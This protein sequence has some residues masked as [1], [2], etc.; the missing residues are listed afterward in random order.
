MSQ[1]NLEVV[2]R[3][4]EAFDRG[5]LSEA[6]AVMAEDVDWRRLDALGTPGSAGHRSVHRRVRRSRERDA[7]AFRSEAEALEAVRLSE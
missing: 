5:E 4:L 7:E 1:E 2:R 3:G 6:L